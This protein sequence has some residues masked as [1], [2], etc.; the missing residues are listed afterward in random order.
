VRRERADG[1]KW[2]RALARFGKWLT[3]KFS[4]KPFSSVYKA[5]LRSNENIFSLTFVLHC[6]KRLQM[7]KTFYGKRFQPKQTEP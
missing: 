1:V 3:E 7:L 2:S 5:I 6:T 4:G